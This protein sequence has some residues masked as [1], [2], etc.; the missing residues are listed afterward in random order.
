MCKCYGGTCDNITYVLEKVSFNMI[1][2][3][4][5]GKLENTKSTNSGESIQ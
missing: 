3:E 4:K 1:Y 2:E 5:P